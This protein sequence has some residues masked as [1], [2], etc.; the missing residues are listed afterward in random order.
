MR[1]RPA[2]STSTIA[3]GAD[4]RSPRNLAS[5]RLRSLMSRMELIAST[6]SSVW[7]GLKPISTGNSLPSFCRPYSSR[8]IPIERVRGSPKYAVRCPVWAR[9][10]RSGTSVSIGRP[11]SS[12]R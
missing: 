11:S 4:S 8:P 10:K 5:A 1:I 7:S 3:S 9:R 6:P 12:S 2:W